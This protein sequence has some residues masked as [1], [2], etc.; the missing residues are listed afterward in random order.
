[1]VNAAAIQPHM[2]PVRE[3]DYESEFRPTLTGEIDL[4][5]LTCQ[6]A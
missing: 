3:M 1:V 2:A 6:A 4:V 5:F